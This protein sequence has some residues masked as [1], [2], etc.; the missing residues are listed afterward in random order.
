MGIIILEELGCFLVIII[1]RAI[2]KVQGS[3]VG[4]TILGEQGYFLVIIIILVELGYFLVITQEEELDYLTAVATAT[5][6]F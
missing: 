4:I 1:I 2:R 6:R 5:P 3:S